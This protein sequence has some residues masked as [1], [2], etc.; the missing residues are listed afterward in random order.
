MTLQLTDEQDRKGK[1]RPGVGGWERAEQRALGEAVAALEAALEDPKAAKRT[2]GL[3][4]AAEESRR[5]ARAAK[6]K[7]SEFDGTGDAARERQRAV[8][9]RAL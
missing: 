9:R 7:V 3:K 1:E 2:A 6:T 8:T 5:V 4:E